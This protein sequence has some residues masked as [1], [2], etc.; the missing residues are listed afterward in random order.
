MNRIFTLIF[1]ITVLAGCG[2][3]RFRAPVSEDKPLFAAINELIKRPD[4]AKAQNDLTYFFNQAVTR[5]EEAASVYRNSA[6]PARWDKLLKELNALQTIYTAT[7]AI[8]NATRFVQP[9]NYLGE[10]EATR[11]NAADFYWQ[12]AMDN[13]E[14][15]DRQS[16]LL[17]FDLFR[18]ASSYVNGYK[19]ANRL[20]Q[21]AWENSIVN[22]VVLPVQENYPTFF[23]EWDPGERYRA[24]YFQEQL[25][26]ELGGKSA[27]HY[28][29]RFF[30]DIEMSND[31]D[32]PD[33][34]LSVKWDYVNTS[35][36][37][38]SREKREVSKNILA[39]RDSTGKQVY[40]LVKATITTTT[41][42]VSA[43]GRLAYTLT[44]TYDRK[45]I[46]IGSSSD[47]VSWTETSIS[48]TGDKRALSDEELKLIKA[49]SFDRGPS[50]TE[51]MDALARKMFPELRRKMERTLST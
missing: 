47:E 33:W 28:P 42:S 22:V 34:E 25:V 37:T 23:R 21:E 15:D 1:I 41:R 13:F 29:A 49:R 14:K 17:A 16:S 5:H 9:K 18:K 35:T 2:S 6:D 31:Y 7:Q 50:K 39:G 40:I 32:R 20:S 26:R 8:P 36:T 44:G 38:P 24:E 51:V 12:Q 30:T 48:Y 19:D 4:N 43:R 3:T 11:E 45:L 46:D 10:L 27:T